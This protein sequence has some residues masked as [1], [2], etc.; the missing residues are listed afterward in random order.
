MA[1]LEPSNNQAPLGA[2][3]LCSDAGARDDGDRM[4]RGWGKATDGIQRK[5]WQW[6]FGG[7]VEPIPF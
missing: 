2:L 4:R 6:C 7:N 3:F 5:G 1:P